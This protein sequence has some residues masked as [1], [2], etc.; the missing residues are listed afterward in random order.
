MRKSDRRRRISVSVQ[1]T[2]IDADLGSKLC[3][4]YTASTYSE[5]KTVMASKLASS[6]TMGAPYIVGKSLGAMHVSN[7]STDQ[8]YCFNSVWILRCISPA[9]EIVK[10]REFEWKNTPEMNCSKEKDKKKFVVSHNC[11][12]QR[13][14][15]CMK[16]RKGSCPLFLSLLFQESCLVRYPCLTPFVLKHKARIFLHDL[17]CTTLTTNIF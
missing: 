5:W 12:C 8:R 16:S 1:S 17:W 6:D 14:H 11:P 3:K 9:G 10:S 2:Y 4:I 13:D 15:A 7:C